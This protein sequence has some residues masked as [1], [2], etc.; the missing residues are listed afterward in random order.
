MLIERDG[1]DTPPSRFACSAGNRAQLG[2]IDKNRATKTAA[3]PS[4][5]M[6]PC[7]RSFPPSDAAAFLCPD[8]TPAVAVRYG[9]FTPSEPQNNPYFTATNEG[10]ELDGRV[11][12]QLKIVGM[13]GDNRTLLFGHQVQVCL[14]QIARRVGIAPLNG[15]E[16]PAMLPTNR[17]PIQ[18]L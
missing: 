4:G 10:D 14:C 13:Q 17:L 11:F 16:N 9:L 7:F 3:A 12:G 18:I 5:G 2:H 6:D 15:L 1:S 8:S